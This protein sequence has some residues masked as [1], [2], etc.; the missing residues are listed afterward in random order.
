MLQHLINQFSVY[1]LSSGRL[2]EGENKLKFLALSS[3]SGRS[4]LRD[5]PDIVILICWKTG[6]CG[7][8][9]RL[10]CVYFS[11]MTCLIVTFLISLFCHLIVTIFLTLSTI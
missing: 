1:Y 4:R 9:G 10:D 5:S 11:S 6:R 8:G 2:R 3:E 7:K